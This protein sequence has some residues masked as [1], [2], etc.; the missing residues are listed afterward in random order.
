[1][2][3]MG[4]K[5]LRMNLSVFANRSAPK[6]ACRCMSFTP[7]PAL[8]LATVLRTQRGVSGMRH[9]LRGQLNVA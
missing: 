7:M 8:H 9:W 2:S 4:F 3:T 6:H 5:R 1:M